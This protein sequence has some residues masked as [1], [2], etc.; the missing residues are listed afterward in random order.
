MSE[1]RD[2]DSDLGKSLREHCHSLRDLS[3]RLKP[4]VI[5]PVFCFRLSLT[6]PKIRLSKRVASGCDRGGLLHGKRR[7]NCG[8]RV[9]QGLKAGFKKR[10]GKRRAKESFH[11]DIEGK[12]GV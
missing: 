2:G 4:E 7:L 9:E 12:V 6:S 3:L 10:L 1:K 11:R 8:V 5:P